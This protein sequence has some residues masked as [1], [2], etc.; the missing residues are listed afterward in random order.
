MLVTRSRVFSENIG[1]IY[2]KFK[3]GSEEME[4]FNVRT[5]QIILN[6][7]VPIFTNPDFHKNTIQR[8]KS[9]QFKSEFYHKDELNNFNTSRYF[10]ILLGQ[11]IR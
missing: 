8:V 6:G 9:V 1:R 7:I 5:F 4:N 2:G 10:L 11:W 3:Q